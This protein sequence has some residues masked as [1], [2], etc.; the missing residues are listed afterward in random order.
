MAEFYSVQI[1]AY[2]EILKSDKDQLDHL[3]ARLFCREHN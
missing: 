1:T 3:T 2:M